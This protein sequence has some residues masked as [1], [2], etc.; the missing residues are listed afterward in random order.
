M[1]ILENNFYKKSAFALFAKF[2]ALK[3]W[4]PTVVKPVTRHTQAC[5]LE[6]VS[7]TNVGVC[8][9]PEDINNKSCKRHV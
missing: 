9:P 5:Y 1:L 6:I 8:V 2:A 7:S 4:R 3:K